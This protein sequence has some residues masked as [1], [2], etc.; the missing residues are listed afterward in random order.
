MGR[1]IDDPSLERRARNPRH[2]GFEALA[3]AS[4]SA[5][6]VVV[7]ATG[8]N[9]FCG[10]ELEVRLAL[11]C[12]E[13]GEWV[14]ERAAFDGYGCTLCVAAADV[15]MEHVVGLPVAEAAQV[16]FDATCAL[17]GGLEVGRTRR[18]CVDLVSRVVRAALATEAA[19]VSLQDGLGEP[20]LAKD[21]VAFEE[22]AV[23]K[24]RSGLAY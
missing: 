10:D 23:D 8:E 4:L 5:A 7:E 6:T 19:R 9:P 24:Q 18:G 11:R 14:V 21:A 16:D 13:A 3:A 20:A 2:R 12:D 15:V 17:I 1:Y 22:N